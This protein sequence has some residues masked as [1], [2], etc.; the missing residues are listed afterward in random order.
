MIGNNNGLLLSPFDCLII[1][2]AS[3]GSSVEG[4]GDALRLNSLH[5][6]HQG[7]VTL[8]LS[9]LSARVRLNPSARSHGSIL[10]GASVT[11]TRLRPPPLTSAALVSAHYSLLTGRN[12]L[13]PW[14]VRPAHPQAHPKLPTLNLRARS[15][16]VPKRSQD[17]I[18]LLPSPD[19]PSALLKHTTV[20]WTRMREAA[21]PRLAMPPI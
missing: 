13:L 12:L 6:D 4:S 1:P 5:L 8:P 10:P 18:S 15:S 17:S 11:A 3:A 9:A 21:R 16:R 7:S 14:P 19:R 2:P 20:P